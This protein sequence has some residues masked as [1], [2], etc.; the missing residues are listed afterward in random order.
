MVSRGGEEAPASDGRGA[1]FFDYEHQVRSRMRV[2]RAE[3]AARASFWTS[4][5]Q[6]APR[7]VR[8]AE[9]SAILRRSDG[10]SK[11]LDI[12]L[13]GGCWCD[14]PTGDAIHALP[15]HGSVH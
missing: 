13:P 4:H 15:V 1:S 11:I 6:S 12:L 10:V 5:T 3:L 7:Q 14:S 9:G 2:A 8:L